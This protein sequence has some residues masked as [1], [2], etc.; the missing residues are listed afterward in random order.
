MYMYSHPCN[1]FLETH[2]FYSLKVVSTCSCHKTENSFWLFFGQKKLFLLTCF[3][4]LT[5]LQRTS[6]NIQVHNSSSIWNAI[7]LLSL[8]L[9]KI[10]NLYVLMVIILLGCNCNQTFVGILKWNVKMFRYN[11]VDEIIC[12]ELA[13]V[14]Y[15]NSNWEQFQSKGSLDE[16]FVLKLLGELLSATYSENKI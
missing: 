9:I 16:A 1:C 15:E 10:D 11:H 3:T 2:W 5:T 4:V 12:Y 13:V 7:F 14:K 8:F 6:Q